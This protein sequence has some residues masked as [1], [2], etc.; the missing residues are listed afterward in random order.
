M[1]ANSSVS[2]LPG[3]RLERRLKGIEIYQEG[4]HLSKIMKGRTRPAL[5][6]GRC[7]RAGGFI[8][9]AIARGYAGLGWLGG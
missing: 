8:Q 4:V 6:G 7:I 2:V 3:E 5:W 9:I 1:V